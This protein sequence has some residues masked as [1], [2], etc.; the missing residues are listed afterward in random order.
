MPDQCSYS[1]D[2]TEDVKSDFDVSKK[3]RYIHRVLDTEKIR[4]RR[5]SLGLTLENAAVAAG[6]KSRQHW[7][8]VEKGTAGGERGI[9]LGTLDAIAKALQCD[10]RELLK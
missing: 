3:T 5:E 2:L 7:F 1:S 4:E 8:L 9:T 6:F 10:P